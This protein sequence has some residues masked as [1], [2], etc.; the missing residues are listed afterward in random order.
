MDISAT[1]A[2]LTSSAVGSGSALPLTINVGA[3]SPE[4]ARFDTSG[5]F[6]HGTTSANGLVGNLKQT[7]GGIF[8]TVNG[9]VSAA[10]TTATTIFTIPNVNAST[11]IISVQLQAG[12]T[13]NYS[14]LAI[15]S[16]Q[17]GSIRF[18]SNTAGALMTIGNSGLNI[19]ATQSSGTTTNIY[20]SAIRIM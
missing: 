9:S 18:M 19:Q 6:L 12:D 2:K 7:V 10:S 16:T 13:A 8:S 11:W 20:Y 17:N 14:A 1:L 15:V 5:N 3:G 4:A